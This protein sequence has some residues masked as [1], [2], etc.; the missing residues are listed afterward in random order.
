[1]ARPPRI[2]VWL[3]LDQTVAYFITICVARRQPILDNPEA[4]GAILKFCD[5]HEQWQT[6]AA[7]VM[8]DHM[9]ALVRPLA[10]RDAKVTQYSAG[11][12]RVVR[13]ETKTTWKWQDGVF[14]RLLRRNEFA[15]SK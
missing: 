14:D 4:F 12:K 5:L 2:P 7:V 13:R 3:P 11:L 9:H 6:I 8:P 1:M 10:S 15:E